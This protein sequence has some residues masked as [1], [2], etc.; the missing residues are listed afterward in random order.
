DAV[1]VR[2][3]ERTPTFAPHPGVR[4]EAQVTGPGAEGER[5]ELTAS[6]QPGVLTGR[7]H[8]TADGVYRIDVQVAGED[9][10][11]T[12]FVRLGAERQEQFQPAQNQALLR[13]IAAAT[14]GRYWRL[15][16][17]GAIGESLVF[18]S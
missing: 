1:E 2:L 6:E 12:R 16:E 11:L 17:A 4:A 8:P 3:V 7:Y 18:A 13:R 14:G 15:D 9:A 5:L 10:P